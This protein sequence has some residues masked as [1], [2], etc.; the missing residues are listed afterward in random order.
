MEGLRKASVTTTL[1]PPPLDDS[2]FGSG[3]LSRTIDHHH[4]IVLSD[5]IGSLICSGTSIADCLRQTDC[6]VNR[7]TSE[8]KM[9]WHTTSGLAALG[10]YGCCLFLSLLDASL[11]SSQTEALSCPAESLTKTIWILSHWFQSP[12][13]RLLQTTT[14]NRY[15]KKEYSQ[16]IHIPFLRFSLD[17][18]VEGCHKDFGIM[19]A[20][21]ST[22][23]PRECVYLGSRRHCST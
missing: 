12:Y 6:T 1:P 3:L 19:Y 18:M 13:D 11:L 9:K 14:W 10:Q 23:H 8:L 21:T 17:L 20:Q 16:A 2:D 5:R 15:Q 4:T 7:T 22:L